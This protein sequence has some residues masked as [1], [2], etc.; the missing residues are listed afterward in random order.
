MKLSS[1]Q[2][3]AKIRIQRSQ[4]RLPPVS[5]PKKPRMPPPPPDSRR[6]LSMPLGLRKRSRRLGRGGR[7]AAGGPAKEA[8]VAPPAPGP[9]RD[10]PQ[11]AGL[12]EAPPRGG[13]GGVA[14]VGGLPPFPRGLPPRGLV[15]PPPAAPA[16]PTSP[17]D[18]VL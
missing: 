15:F 17:V 4:G 12:G 11:A 18:V 9:A 8:G 5:L 3:T 14:G 6:M 7:C 1:S 2:P 10:P 13:G 16:S